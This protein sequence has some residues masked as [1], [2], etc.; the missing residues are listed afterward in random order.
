M[1]ERINVHSRIRGIVEDR[2]DRM[3]DFLLEW[4]KTMDFLK[5]QVPMAFSE[6]DLDRIQHLMK[7]YHMLRRRIEH[8]RLFIEKWEHRHS[9][10]MNDD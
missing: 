2:F 1:D 7:E 8:V 9:S 3:R 5:G 6:E 10:I 4:G